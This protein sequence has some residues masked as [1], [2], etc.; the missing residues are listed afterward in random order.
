MDNAAT[1]AARPAGQSGPR[2]SHKNPPT[3]AT[4]RWREFKTKLF[5]TLIRSAQAAIFAFAALLLGGSIFAIIGKPV[6]LL[7]NWIWNWY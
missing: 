7:I 3:M 5:T 4:I 6:W 2:L 1:E